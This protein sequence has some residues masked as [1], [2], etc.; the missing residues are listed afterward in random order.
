MCFVERT[1]SRWLEG[2]FRNQIW[3]KGPSGEA[4]PFFRPMVSD[5]GHQSKI[6]LKAVG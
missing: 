4:P 1:G 2:D 5:A 3:K 6:Q